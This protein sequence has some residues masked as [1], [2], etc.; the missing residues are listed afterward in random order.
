MG[1]MPTDPVE[2]RK[3]ARDL[4]ALSAAKEHTNEMRG[5]G[6]D[7]GVRRPGAGRSQLPA[8]SK[9]FRA[10]ALFGTPWGSVGEIKG[11]R[12]TERQ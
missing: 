11:T 12:A 8:R 9:I 4:K 5:G 2:F 7:P 10:A 3:C 1:P 6:H